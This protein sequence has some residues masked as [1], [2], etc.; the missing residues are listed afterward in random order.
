MIQ[1]NSESKIRKEYNEEGIYNFSNCIS[2]HK[3]G[4]E[5][6]IEYND[7]TKNKSAQKD[8]NDVKN[9]INSNNKDRKKEHEK[10]RKKDDDD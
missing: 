6:E 4:N 9:Y 5:H 7:K 10:R 8:V 2:C 3:S 1:I